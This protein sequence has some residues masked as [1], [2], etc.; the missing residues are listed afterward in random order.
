MIKSQGTPVVVEA[1]DVR[2]DSPTQ[3][4]TWFTFPAPRQLG[5]YSVIVTNPDGSNCS[6]DNGFEV[7]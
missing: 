6:L 2:W 7:K 3:V 1:R 5:N 4:S